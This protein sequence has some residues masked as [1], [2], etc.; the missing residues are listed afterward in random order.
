MPKSRLIVAQIDKKIFSDGNLPVDVQDTLP[1]H[2]GY[3]YK[4]KLWGGRLD[5]ALSHVLFWSEILQ[6][7][8][9]KEERNVILITLWNWKRTWFQ[10][11][12]RLKLFS[13]GQTSKQ[14]SSCFKD[15]INQYT[16]T[17]RSS[18]HD[19]SNM[20]LFIHTRSSNL[21]WSSVNN[22]AKSCPS[23]P[24]LWLMIS[25]LE[26]GADCLLPDEKWIS[27]LPKKQTPMF[28][29]MW[30]NVVSS[31]NANPRFA[32]KKWSEM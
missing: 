13:S 3:S 11:P 32:H 12:H 28:R 14:L 21:S 8:P 1:V 7:W 2:F 18:L 27:L 31:C 23:S 9:A 30:R 10:C 17:L 26:F 19:I 6:A 25:Q 20:P 29:F 22:F 24:Y 16:F 4:R 15:H 5:L